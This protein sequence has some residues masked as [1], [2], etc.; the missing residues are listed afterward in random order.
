MTTDRKNEIE[1]LMKECSDLIS[2]YRSARRCHFD[3][4][5]ISVEKDFICSQLR[6]RAIEASEFCEVI[7]N[8]QVPETDN[9]YDT[10]AEVLASAG[11]TTDEVWDYSLE[12][13]EID[14]AL[15]IDENY[16]DLDIEELKYVPVHF[17]DLADD[18]YRLCEVGQ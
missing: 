16:D 11:Y 18:Y 12:T 10:Y 13:S 9:S 3:T 2:A 6:D 4:E 1:A 15:K 14:E 8:C 7:Y 17:V 5:T